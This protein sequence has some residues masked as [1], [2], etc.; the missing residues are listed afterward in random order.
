MRLEKTFRA[1]KGVRAFKTIT[2][3]E[4]DGNQ[5]LDAA[6]WT[7]MRIARTKLKADDFWGRAKIEQEE[8][9]RACIVAVDG[10][11]VQ[12]AGAPWSGFDKWPRS[13][14]A[15]ATRFFRALNDLDEVDLEKCVTE[16]MGEMTQ[17]ES[18]TP[19]SNKTGG[20]TTGGSSEG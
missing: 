13:S 5:D 16:A 14:K 6:N 11:Q 1:P 10:V 9:T 17:E 8:R 3:C 18:V 20:A 2:V 7:D 19:R 15:A 12:V 4:L